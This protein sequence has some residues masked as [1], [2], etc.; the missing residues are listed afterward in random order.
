[1]NKAMLLLISLTLGAGNAQ[2]ALL[3]GD[4]AQGK[5]VH[6]KQCVACHDSSVYTRAN[7]QV[8]SP[9]ALIGQVN[10]CIRQ[11]GAKLDRDQVNGL[12]KYLD[13]SFYKFK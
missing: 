5:A 2:A 6:D 12:V 7:R 4:A 9:E 8:K 3:P 10:N 11:T 13:E 1:M